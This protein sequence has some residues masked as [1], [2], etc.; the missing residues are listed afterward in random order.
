MLN[1]LTGT[2]HAELR[3]STRAANS[4]NLQSVESLKK[5]VQDSEPLKTYELLEYHE[6]L[7]MT[8]PRIHNQGIKY[9]ITLTG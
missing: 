3:S 6:S 4:L 5:L 2:L 8:L 7:S 1:K 9:R